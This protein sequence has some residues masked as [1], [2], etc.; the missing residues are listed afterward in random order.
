MLLPAGLSLR[1]VES[2]DRAFLL[3]LLATTSDVVQAL[4]APAQRD[5]LLA[6]QLD[7][8][9]RSHR[10]RFP[11][12]CFDVIESAAEP[13]GRLSVDR[14]AKALWLVDIAVLSAWRG[15]GIGTAI[16]RALQQE[17]AQTQR[18]V[19]LHVRH[20]NRAE[21]LYRRLGFLVIAE[22]AL[23]RDLEWRY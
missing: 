22:H 3:G 13:I 10:A 6:L 4:L 5:A 16:V 8:Q 23:G 2:A 1:P 17:A 7:A 19:A 9:Q 20:G 15:H 21:R 11:D 12:A 18:R 14:G